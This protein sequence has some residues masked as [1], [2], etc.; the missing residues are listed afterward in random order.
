[1]ATDQ[2]NEQ[3]QMKVEAMIIK[4]LD[5]AYKN[6][7][8]SDRPEAE[9]HLGKVAEMKAFWEGDKGSVA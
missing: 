8:I 9:E 5:L 4:G 2:A 3:L 6:L 1:M 7:L